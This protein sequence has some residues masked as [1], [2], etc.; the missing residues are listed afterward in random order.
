VRGRHSRGG[1]GGAAV[2]GR[3][4][5]VLLRLY[6]CRFNSYLYNIEEI[7]V[8]SAAGSSAHPTSYLVN[9]LP[10]VR[11]RG[12]RELRHNMLRKVAVD[13]DQGERT[14]SVILPR[15]AVLP[16][17]DVSSSCC[18][19]RDFKK[20]P[21]HVHVVIPSLIF[22]ISYNKKQHNQR[23]KRRNEEKA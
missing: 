19:W 16:Q 13:G 1:S 15:C 9:F 10:N 8:Y 6:L 5:P 3:S 2:G 14:A 4:L 12:S 21:V 11:G 17:R 23:A 20:V 7:I 22:Q 18:E